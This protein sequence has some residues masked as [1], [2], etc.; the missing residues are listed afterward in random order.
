MY[1]FND[2]TV[3]LTTYTVNQINEIEMVLATDTGHLNADAPEKGGGQ[4]RESGVRGG[5]DRESA[6]REDRGQEIATEGRGR[7]IGV[8]GHEIDAIDAVVDLEVMIGYTRGF[9]VNRILYHTILYHTILQHTILQHTI[10][11]HNI[12]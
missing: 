9:S 3:V 7:E 1:I 10:L 6:V 11:Q 5:R 2:I 4:G 12:L 8:R